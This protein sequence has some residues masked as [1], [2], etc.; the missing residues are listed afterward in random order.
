MS[1]MFVLLKLGEQRYKSKVSPV[2]SL[3]RTLSLKKIMFLQT[4]V[5]PRCTSQK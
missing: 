1:E 2:N 3:R 5:F 4:N